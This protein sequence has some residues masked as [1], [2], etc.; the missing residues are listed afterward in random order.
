MKSVPTALTVCYPKQHTSSRDKDAAAHNL[1]ELHSRSKTLNQGQYHFDAYMYKCL[2]RIV[3][4]FL[5]VL[6]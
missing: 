3:E 4:V 6:M 2:H 5:V 1:G